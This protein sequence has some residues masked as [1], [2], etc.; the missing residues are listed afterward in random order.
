MNKIKDLFIPP[1]FTIKQALKRMDETGRKIVFVVDLKYRLLGVATDG[2]L[3]KWILRGKSLGK[4][5]SLAMNKE[6]VLLFEGSSKEEAKDKMTRHMVECI[7]LVNSQK[8]VVSAIWWLDIFEDKFKKH[9]PIDAPVVIMAG[10]QG[11]RLSPFTRVLPKPLLPIGEKPIIEHVIEN[12]LGYGC[13]NFYVSVNYKANILKAYFHDFKHEYSINY[14]EENMP[15]GTIGSL[16]LLK[17]RIKR[18]FFVSNCD[19][20]VDADYGDILKFHESS[21]NWITMV[22]SMKHYTIPY[23]VCEIKKGGELKGIRE[24]PEYDLL[25]NAGFYLMKSQVLS[26]IPIQKQYDLTDLLNDSI[27]NGKKIGVYPVSEKCW[28]DMGQLEQLREIQRR[29]DIK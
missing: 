9:T 20:L 5:I 25:V 6:P 11:E 27:S 2:D 1:R 14:L 16:S 12:F 13:R 23:G 7:P 29:F 26:L 3:R 17:G 28:L 8:Q 4:P 19:I 18:S 24:K 15:L 21:G 10:G 22:V